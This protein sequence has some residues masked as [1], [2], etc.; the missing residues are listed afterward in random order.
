[1][2]KLETTDTLIKTGTKAD[3]E[4]TERELNKVSGG[5]VNW[6]QTSAWPAFV[7]NFWHAKYGGWSTR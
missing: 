4:L 1:M 7:T 5:Q 3:V 2:S 6:V